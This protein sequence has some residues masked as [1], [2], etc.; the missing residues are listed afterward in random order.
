MSKQLGNFYIIDDCIE[1]FGADATRIALADAGDTLD[2]ANFVEETA[3][4]SISR[5]YNIDTWIKWALENINDMRESTI[6]PYLKFIDDAFNQEIDKCASFTEKAY[7]HMKFRDVLKY[8]L[9]DLISNKEDYTLSCRNEAKLMNKNLILKYI[10][11]QL[12]LLYP[13]TP[14]FSEIIYKEQLRKH[15]PSSPEFISL[16]S[17]PSV[18]PT[19]IDFGII[20]AKNYIKDLNRSIRTGLDKFKNK[21]KTSPNKCCILIASKYFD[22]Q[23]RVLDVLMKFHSVDNNQISDE[24]KKE[25]LGESDKEIMKKSLMFG[26]YIVVFYFFVCY[27][28]GSSW[29]FGERRFCFADAIRRKGTHFQQ[30]R[31]IN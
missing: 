24:W 18:D 22:W 10:H 2:D 13:I 3:N 15:L 21:N 6:D 16:D 14:H 17:F 27:I 4:S 29:T 8:G 9:Y 1:K 19:K 31:E 25:F 20:R 26:S 11:Y 12:L 30:S 23:L 28:L 7:E 5:L